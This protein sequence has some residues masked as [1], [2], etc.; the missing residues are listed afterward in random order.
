MQEIKEKVRVVGSRLEEIL[1]D[2]GE[3]TGNKA[4][5]V[6]KLRLQ[7]HTIGEELK[8][9][10]LIPSRDY[11]IIRSFCKQCRTNYSPNAIRRV[12]GAIQPFY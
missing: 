2:G 12:V 7:L 10:G 4:K 9:V 6:N 5:E 1:K 3:I 11:R 8:G